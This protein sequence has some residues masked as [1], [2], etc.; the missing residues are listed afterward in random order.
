MTSTSRTRTTIASAWFTVRS[1]GLELLSIAFGCFAVA[2]GAWV[3]GSVGFGY[4]LIAAPLLA[5]VS[6]GFVPGPVM[7]SSMLV[8]AAGAWRERGS[9]DRAGVAWALAGRVPGIAVG[10]S[11]LAMMPADVAGAVFGGL[12]LLA[13]AISVSGLRVPLAPRSLLG[14][15]FV[16]G[17]MGTMT[18]I[19]GPPMALL[20]QDASGPSLRATLNTYFA[21]GS[22]MSLPALA[23]AGHFGRAELISALVLVPPTA[24]GFALS[25][26]SRAYLDAGRVRPAVLAVSGAA[27]LAVVVKALA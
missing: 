1:E 25:S 23:L 2:L 7:A 19:G 15:G 16:S 3:Q 10:A 18:S 20:Y 12:V 5:L 21:L 4:A 17:V 14:T 26:R 22:A 24:L 13:V 27:A 9:L 8:S 11:A 6:E